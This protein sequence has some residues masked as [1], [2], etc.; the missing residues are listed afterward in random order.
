MTLYKGAKLI[1]MDAF[2]RD[3]ALEHPESYG[4]YIYEVEE[5]D[6]S[7]LTVKLKVIR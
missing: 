6:Y 7:T 4:H 1:M 5:V 2:Q 3:G